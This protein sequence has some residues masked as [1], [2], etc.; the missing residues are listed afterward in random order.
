MSGLG[1]ALSDLAG[2]ARKDGGGALLDEINYRATNLLGERGL[3]VDTRGLIQIQRIAPNEPDLRDST[4]IGYGAVTSV[5]KSLPIDRSRSG[6]LDYGSGKGRACVVAAHL[7]FEPV[8]GVELSE[9]LAAVARNNL[10]GMRRR[11]SRRAEIIAADARSFEVPA[12][13]NVAYFFNPFVG[14][15]LDAVV[16]NLR[17]SVELTPREFWVVFFNNG[18]FD[19]VADVSLWLEKQAQRSFYPRLSCGVYRRR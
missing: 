14:P 18:D 11:R 17:R 2:L 12:D 4:P 5:L 16:S 9:E 13:I 15:P 8:I 1:R 3:G 6:F 10:E 7:G 19:R